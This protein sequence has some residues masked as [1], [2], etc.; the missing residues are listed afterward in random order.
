M[1][2]T[3][4]CRKGWKKRYQGATTRLGR[5]VAWVRR[6]PQGPQTRHLG[7]FVLD[8]RAYP[9]ALG[10]S[11]IT[12]NKKEGDGATPSGV[13][14]IVDGRFRADRVRRPFAAESFWRRINVDDGWCDAPFTPAYNRP[15]TLPHPASHEILE[16]EDGLYDR[17]IVLDWN[18]TR[19]SHQRGSAIFLH[20]ARFKA[21]Q[22]QGTEGCIAL[23]AAVFE[24]LATRLA[25]L[26]AVIVL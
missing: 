2:N 25:R 8:G 20:H 22:M 3:P 18:V 19:R 10:R 9:C 14:A 17:L 13:M 26:D 1:L 4:K 11:G 5:S 6:A 24:R 7:R 12:I 15:V 16:R 21:G 23:E